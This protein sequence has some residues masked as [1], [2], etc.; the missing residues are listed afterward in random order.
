MNAAQI[1]SQI[2]QALSILNQHLLG[3]DVHVR[4]LLLAAISGE[5]VLLLGPPGTAKSELARRLRHVLADAQYFERL[6]TRFSVPEE[7][8]GP[9]SL[10]ALEQDR[11]ERLTQGYL[12]SAHIAFLDEIFKA[13]SAILNA[14]LT[15]LNEKEFDNGSARERVPLVTLV[16]ASNEV[17]QEDGLQAFYDRFLLRAPVQ[18]VPEEHFAELLTLAAFSPPAQAVLTVATLEQTRDRAQNVA[19]PEAVLALLVQARAWSE[20]NQVQVSD[21]RWRKLVDLLKVQAGSAG[22]DA[23]LPMDLWLLAFVLAAQPEQCAALQEWFERSVARAVP[24]DVQWLLR[25]LEAFEKQLEIEQS[26][27]SSDDDSAGKMALAKAITGEQAARDANLVRIVS[28]RARKRY[29]PVHVQARSAQA[30]EV[31]QRAELALQAAQEA[32]GQFHAQADAHLW[33]PPSWLARMAAQ[34]EANVSVAQQCLERTSEVQ[35]GFEALPQDAQASS[36]LPQPL[37]LD[38]A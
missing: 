26:A 9:L 27:Q 5:H 32:Q 23:V 31:L 16:G 28:E 13:N 35:Q 34:H 18:P 29:S 7:L 37:A 19:L 3:R 6:L 11:Y 17:P 14:L 12:P 25:A 8:F 33:L 15:L 2:K 4:L 22:R 30:G 36:E 24:L 21:R 20:Q 10:K 1:Q 38:F